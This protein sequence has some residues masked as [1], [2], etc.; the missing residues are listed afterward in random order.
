MKQEPSSLKY[1]TAHNGQNLSD[2]VV[3]QMGMRAREMHLHVNVIC[4]IVLLVEPV[5]EHP[6]EVAEIIRVQYEVLKS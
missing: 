3:Q 1:A 4:P 6:T 5:S 2:I